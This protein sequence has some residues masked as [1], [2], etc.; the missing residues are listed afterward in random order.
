[1]LNVAAFVGSVLVAAGAAAA[2]LGAV[3]ALRTPLVAGGG[4]T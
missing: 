3:S 1:V 4:P 2:A